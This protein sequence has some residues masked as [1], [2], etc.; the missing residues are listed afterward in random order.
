VAAALKNENVTTANLNLSETGD[1]PADADAVIIAG[2]SISFS[3]IEAEAL[4]RYLANNGKLLVLLDPYVTLGLDD[5]LKKYGMKYEDDLILYRA[6][7]ST[8]EQETLALAY[9]YQGGFAAQPVTAKF[10]Q[11]NVQL[12]IYDARSITLATDKAQ[13]PRIQFL[14]QTDADAW[15]W[16]SLTGAAPVNPRQVTYNKVTDI[17]GPL[18]V[19]AQYDGGMTTDPKTKA[20]VPATRLVAVGA[21]RFLE[22]DMVTDVGANFFTNAVDWLVKKDAVLDISPK[23]PQEYGVSLNPIS[24]RT[25]VWCAIFFIPGAALLMGI[26]TWLSRRK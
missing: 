9:I 21:A 15:G 12:L 26:F 13:P 2:P 25:V 17:A 11:A 20:T 7:T 6:A 18:T 5:L 14:L 8:G 3:A 22:N 24:Y 23:K 16:I 19:A 1:V 4:D 10:A